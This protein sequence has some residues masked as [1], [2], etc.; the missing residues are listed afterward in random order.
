MFQF[1][2]EKKKVISRTKL[3]RQNG[4]LLCV[5]WRKSAATQFMGS[6]LNDGKVF[7]TRK[8]Q[9][10]FLANLKRHLILTQIQKNGNSLK[11]QTEL[12]AQVFNASKCVISTHS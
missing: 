2:R 9:L 12:M 6:L 5:Q 10:K 3:F 1:E 4:P 8:V 11:R 7:K